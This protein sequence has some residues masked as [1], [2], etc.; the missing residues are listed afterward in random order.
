VERERSFPVNFSGI[1]LGLTGE[2]TLS[3]WFNPAAFCSG[4]RSG[5]QLRAKPGLSFGLKLPF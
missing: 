4:L 5:D 1:F 2:R 3:R